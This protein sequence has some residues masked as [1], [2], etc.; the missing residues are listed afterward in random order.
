MAP[1]WWSAFATWWRAAS[2]NAVRP[3]PSSA[4]VPA[5]LARGARCPSPPNIFEFHERINTHL[6][7]RHLHR[8]LPGSA[9]PPPPPPSP[10]PPPPRPP[11]PPPAR[12]PPPAPPR[13]PPPP[14]PPAPGGEGGGGGRPGGAARGA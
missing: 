6:H 12:A 11:P 4:C 9:P 8:P 7:R 13:P 1:R 14:P 3:R 2:T 5:P 10:P